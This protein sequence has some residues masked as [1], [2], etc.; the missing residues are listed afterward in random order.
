M[1]IL[2]PSSEHRPLFLPVTYLVD[3]LAQEE[4]FVCLVLIAAGGFPKCFYGFALLLQHVR[5]PSCYTPHQ[6]WLLSA[7]SILA[8]FVGVYL[9]FLFLI[10]I[11]YIFRIQLLCQFYRL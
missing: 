9:S 10:C 1:N 4:F 2:I 8:I 11:V 7:L 3:T 5:V 6:Y